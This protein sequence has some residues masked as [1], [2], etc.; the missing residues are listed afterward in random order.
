MPTARVVNA[1]VLDPI[2]NK[3]LGPTGER[4]LRSANPNPLVK[5]I[6]RSL[7]TPTATPGSEI[8]YVAITCLMTASSASVPAVGSL[9]AGPASGTGARAT[10]AAPPAM[11]SRRAIIMRPFPPHAMPDRK[12]QEQGRCARSRFHRH[13]SPATP[14][15]STTRGLRQPT[16]GY[17]LLISTVIPPRVLVLSGTSQ[18]VIS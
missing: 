5:K 18:T 2:A 15:I 1:F 7:I 3:V 14:E 8:G 16:F 13:R 10:T 4:A 6:W 12:P 17:G 11:K 9:R